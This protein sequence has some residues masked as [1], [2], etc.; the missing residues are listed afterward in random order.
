MKRSRLPAAT[1]LL[2]AVL[3]VSVHANLSGT[4]KTIALDGSL[5]DWNNPADVLYD[6]AEIGV[7]TPANSTY[8]VAYLANDAAYLY[9][10]LDT[11]GTNG[12]SIS[13]TWTH[14]IYLDTDMNPATGF[15]AGWMA[16]GYDHLIQYGT[17]GGAYGVFEFSGTTQGTWGWNFMGLI[18]YAYSNDVAELAV[19]LANLGVVAGDSF[20]MELN[21]AGVGVTAETWAHSD[22]AS[23]ETYIS[24]VFSNDY[25]VIVVDGVL[26]EWNNPSDVFYNDSEITDGEP[27][28]SSYEDIYVVNNAENL[29]IGLDTKGTGGGNIT[30][31]WTRN[32]YLDTDADGATGFNG[33]WMSHG[34][35]RLIQYGGGVYSVYEFTG[36]T[37]AEWGWNFLGEI[38]YAFGDDIVEMSVPLN[39]LGVA[40]GDS[41]VIELTVSGTGI[42]TETWASEFESGAKTYVL[43]DNGTLVPIGTIVLAGPVS[44]PGG[45]GMTVSWNSDAG[46]S[47]TVEYKNS[48]PTDPAWTAYTNLVSQGGG[49]VTVTTA[50]SQAATFYRVVSP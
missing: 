29:Y 10:G 17:A 36:A 5:D 28:N 48:L 8:E 39:L 46:Q 45:Q 21:V 7:G 24:A 22:E 49:G 9:I 31:T 14:N 27:A 18:S 25:P 38:T 19:S 33:G 1:A 50:V 2:C 16:H 30:N 43:L 23:A 40:G 4:F 35:D 42:S 41:L 15:N 20:V 12:G 44:T 32:V 34:Y 47:Y 37:Q 26:N 6:A 3:S 13:N 11:A